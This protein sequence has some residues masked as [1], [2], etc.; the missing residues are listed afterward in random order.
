MAQILFPLFEDA[1]GRILLA[2]M[3][4]PRAASAEQ[5]SSIA[6]ELDT[7]AE[8]CP[9]VASAMNAA[10]SGEQGIIVVAGSVFLVGEVQALIDRGEWT[11]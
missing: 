9:D 4:N 6:T 11:T 3:N 1:G 2:P 5:L 8:V 7:K 10:L